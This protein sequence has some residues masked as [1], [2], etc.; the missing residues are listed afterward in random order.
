MLIKR[1]SEVFRAN[2]GKVSD[3]WESYLGVYDSV[4]SSIEMPIETVLEIG[5]QNGGSLEVWSKVA[6]EA[7][8]IL[9]IDVN[10]LCGELEFAD[11]RIRVAVTDGSQASLMKAA[12]EL[13]QPLSIIVDDASHVSRDIIENFISLWP[14]L[15]PGGKFIIEDLATSY[16][17][18]YDGGLEN[19][20]AAMEFLKKL[21]DVVNSEHWVSEKPLGMFLRNGQVQVSD[22]F[23]SCVR[24]IESLEFRNSMCLITKRMAESPFGIGKRIAV[25]QLAS[26]DSLPLT[27]S[28]ISIEESGI[29]PGPQTLYKKLRQ[30]ARL[31]IQNWNRK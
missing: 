26:V 14:L 24:E 16:W 11:S 5:V 4:L 2:D 12:T 13:G 15:A 25:G 27:L 9:G 30:T 28:N 31:R 6:P 20:N 10:P 1:Y 23:L 7:K 21:T 8:A 3:K 18:T 22:V 17:H 19:R 29:K